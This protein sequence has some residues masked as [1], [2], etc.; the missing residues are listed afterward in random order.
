MK[1]INQFTI[2]IAMLMV[3]AMLTQCKNIP[4]NIPELFQGEKDYRR[5]INILFDVSNSI[6]EKQLNSYITAVEIAFKNLGARDKLSIGVIDKGSYSDPA[7]VLRV[8]LLKVKTYDDLPFGYNKKVISATDTAWAGPPFHRPEEMMEANGKARMEKRLEHFKAYALPHIRPML[9]RMFAERKPYA[10]RS[11]ILWAIRNVQSDL[12][13]DE[14]K[15]LLDHDLR[16]HN[17][18]IILSDMIQTDDEI[19]FNKPMGILRADAE[20]LLKRIAGANQLPA[21]GGANVICLGRATSSIIKTEEGVQRVAD[22]WTEYFGS[23]YTNGR[24][25]AYESTDKSDK[26]SDWLNEWS[27]NK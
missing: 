13:K 19:S 7:S 4:T 16:P 6:S 17:Y 20:Q 11:N 15:L 24:L 2:T 12:E 9:L 18:L 21:L 23:K 25:V 14:S 3:I 8:D 27:A 10:D 22:F 26:L 1:S 5:N